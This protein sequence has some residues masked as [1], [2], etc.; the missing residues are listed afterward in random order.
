MYSSICHHVSLVGLVRNLT[1]LQIRKYSN[2][3]ESV[4]MMIAQFVSPI[5]SLSLYR[6]DK[7]PILAI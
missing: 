5:R 1:A 2:I 3:G 4:I 7:G 6:L